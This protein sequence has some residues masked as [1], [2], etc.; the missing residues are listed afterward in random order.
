L[1]GE[2]RELRENGQ[3]KSS[4]GEPDVR[5]APSAKTIVQGGSGAPT[6]LG[7]LI[8]GES[9][10]MHGNQLKIRRP[11]TRNAKK[12]IVSV[13]KRKRIETSTGYFKKPS[14]TNERGSGPSSLVPCQSRF[15]RQ[16]D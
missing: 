15:K 3:T 5:A 1:W 4:L 11:R 9:E 14:T 2:R 10:S 12:A 16:P 8:Q 13:G 7:V 6:D